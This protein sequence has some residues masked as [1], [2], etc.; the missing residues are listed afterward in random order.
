MCIEPPTATIFY[1]DS[2]KSQLL[3][4]IDDLRNEFLCTSELECISPPVVGEPPCAVNSLPVD[5]TSA[6]DS[7]AVNSIDGPTNPRKI[8]IAGDSL[9][10]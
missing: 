4:K 9:L 2:L 6:K 1:L 7:D 5:V 10:H 3:E 8:L